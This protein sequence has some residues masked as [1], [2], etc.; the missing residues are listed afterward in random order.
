MLKKFLT[1]AVLS[2]VTAVFVVV[3]MPTV[4]VAQDA[5]SVARGGRLYDKWYKVIDAPKPSETH[6]AWPSSNTKKKGD[7]TQRCKACHG[8][9]LRGADGA[10]AAGSYKTGI[11][12][13]RAMENADTAK[14]IAIIKDS[15]HGFGG[16]M[17]DRDY[18]DL[19]L[20]V[21]KGQVDMTKLINAD[22]TV[23]GDAVQGKDYYNTL[24]ANC[25]G[26][27]G[28]LPKELPKPMGAIAAGNPWEA[29]Q[30]IQNG[31]PKEKMPALRALPLQVSVDV[32]AY[33]VT[34]P[35]D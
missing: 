33:T 20:F 4:S 34:L 3:A 14:I 32:L 8:W 17:S 35:K 26:V 9:D 6:K 31:Q 12:G 19:A 5:A 29:L 10:Y 15:L 2:C 23:N 18:D 13:V 1:S 7:A 21:S 27:D 28:K 11:K 16:K 30:K 24:C 25:H 22:K